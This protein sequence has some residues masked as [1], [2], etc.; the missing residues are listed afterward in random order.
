MTALTK[1]ADFRIETQV[2]GG[3]VTRWTQMVQKRRVDGVESQLSGCVCIKR[4]AT[5]ATASHS[6]II[7]EIEG[8]G[9]FEFIVFVRSSR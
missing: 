4:L 5:Y 9:V 6:L 8:K 2:S 7:F 1:M 3:A